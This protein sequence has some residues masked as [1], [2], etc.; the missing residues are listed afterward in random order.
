MIAPLLWEQEPRFLLQGLGCCGP[1]RS[2]SAGSQKAMAAS[3]TAPSRSTS[4][5][6]GRKSWAGARHARL[7]NHGP[8]EAPIT[9][10]NRTCQDTLPGRTLATTPAKRISSALAFSRR[11]L[12]GLTGTWLPADQQVHGSNLGEA[13][14][15]LVGWAAVDNPGLQS[16]N[17][18]MLG[19]RSS[20][21]SLERVYLQVGRNS[22]PPAG[23]EPAIFGLE[24][25]RLV[26]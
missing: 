1:L 11:D 19:A 12:R 25:R 3:S 26:H 7:L 24:V 20:Y 17:Q 18:K 22:A 5:H 6:R 14:V 13:F 10:T 8:E 21:F 9:S 15:I 2:Q 16:Q 4:S 23:L